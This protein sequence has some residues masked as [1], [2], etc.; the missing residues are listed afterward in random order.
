MHS[1][2]HI[3]NRQRMIETIHTRECGTPSG[4][5]PRTHT[6][7][8]GFWH[9]S[10]EHSPS[11]PCRA[12][13]MEATICQI[14]TTPL[15]TMSQI[16]LSDPILSCKAQQNAKTCA[17]RKCDRE[18]SLATLRTCATISGSSWH[19]A[20]LIAPTPPARIA[21]MTG[22]TPFTDKPQ[23]DKSRSIGFFKVGRASQSEIRPEISL[24]YSQ[25]PLPV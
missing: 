20:R 8:H 13:T 23:S 22:F 25:S 12:W 11:C 18:T 16:A 3:S 9:A 1:N 17:T 10:V 21:W 7:Y 6:S 4:S 2:N 24:S 15:S 19:L 14:S 5:N